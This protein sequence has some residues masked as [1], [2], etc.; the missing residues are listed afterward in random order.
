MQNDTLEEDLDILNTEEKSIFNEDINESLKDHTLSS[1]L[2]NIANFYKP[3]IMKKFEHM[4]LFVT[5]MQQQ[6]IEKETKLC[7]ENTER[8]EELKIICNVVEQNLQDLTCIKEMQDRMLE[9]IILSNTKMH[10]VLRKANDEK[11]DLQR[12]TKH[13]QYMVQML[14]EENEK[15]RI[16]LRKCHHPFNCDQ[17]TCIKYEDFMKKEQVSRILEL[18]NQ[19]CKFK[20]QQKEMVTSFEIAK[21]NKKLDDLQD[22]C[23]TLNKKNMKFKLQMK[24]E[25]TKA[26]SKKSR[27]LSNLKIVIE[28]NLNNYFIES[29]YVDDQ[30]LTNIRVYNSLI[31]LCNLTELM[32]KRINKIKSSEVLNKKL[33]IRDI[34]KTYEK[35]NEVLKDKLSNKL[36]LEKTFNIDDFKALNEDLRKDEMNSS[37]LKQLDEN[38]ISVKEINFCEKIDDILEKRIKFSENGKINKSIIVEEQGQ[39]EETDKKKTEEQSSTLD[40]ILLTSSNINNETHFRTEMD[41]NSVRTFKNILLSGK[42]SIKRPIVETSENQKMNET[43]LDKKEKLEEEEKKDN[44]TS[45]QYKHSSAA[46]DIVEGV[47]NRFSKTYSFNDNF[48]LCHKFI[49]KYEFGNNEF[50][51]PESQLKFIQTDVRVN[52]NVDTGCFYCH[53]AIYILTNVK[54]DARNHTN[55]WRS[56]V[57]ESMPDEIYEHIKCIHTEYDNK[58]KNI[59]MR[60]NSNMTCNRTEDLMQN[61][62][63]VENNTKNNTEVVIEN[64]TSII[65][66]MFEDMD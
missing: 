33:E 56:K 44:F 30:N 2:E 46:N 28:K 39:T 7:M 42:T 53:T 16:Q 17:R 49:D 41:Y 66:D 20:E 45:L 64:T 21:L 24:T 26:S 18:V 61:N 51:Q 38:N 5:D 65:D 48:P 14:Q 32:M 1:K 29:R 4:L 62:L 10:E 50:Q 8:I 23:N 37:N 55:K 52:S 11:K 43:T 22:L 54:G 3:E 13:L 27:L 6:N 31:E 9:D 25:N 63:A 59:K 34:D 12:E 58:T 35:L 19:L 36:D 40:F 47:N 15:L 60:T 57:V